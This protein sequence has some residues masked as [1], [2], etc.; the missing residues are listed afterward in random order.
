VERT[1]SDE[2]PP[3]EP[4]LDGLPEGVIAATLTGEILFWN[5]AAETIFGLPREA[6]VGRDLVETIIAAEDLEEVRGKLQGAIAAGEGTFECVGRRGDASRVHVDLSLKVS[7]GE[8][9]PSQVV[10]CI[11]DVTQPNIR[12]QAAELDLRFRGLLEAVPDAKVIVNQEGYIL[13]VNAQ[14]ERLFGYSRTELVGREVELL[15]PHRFRGKHPGHRMGYTADPRHRP[16]G[17]GMELFGL[18]KDGTEFPVEISL[19]SLKTDQGVLVFSAIRDITEQKRLKEELSRQYRSL[20][21]A[22]RLKSEFLANMSHELRTPLNAIIGFSELIHDAKVGPVTA[23][24]QEYLND[25]LNSSRH[26]LQLINDVLDLAK[27][28]AGKIEFRPAPLVLSQV[29]G[30]VRDILRTLAAQKRI[31][32]AV[33]IDPSVIGVVADPARLKQVLYNYLSNALKFS[34]DEGRVS[35]RVLA[36]GAREFRL[37]VEDVGIGIKAED[38]GRLFV[39]F[40]QLDASTAKKYAG[41]GLGLALTKRIVEAQQGRVGVESTPGKGSLFY[42]VLPRVS[43]EISEPAAV[44]PPRHEGGPHVLVIEDDPKDSDWLVRTLTDA[45]YTV[46]AARNGDEALRRSR[47]Q[48]FDAITL[49]LLLPDVSGRD[50]L[51]AIRDGLNHDTPVVIVSVVAER[52]IGTGFQV[53]DIFQKPVRSEELLASLERAA[54]LPDLSRPV[55]VVDDDASTLKLAETT[56]RQAGYWP[57]CCASATEALVAAAEEPPALVVLDLLMPEMDGFEFLRHFRSTGQGRRTPVIVWTV[58]DLTPGEREALRASARIV[59]AKGD[60]PGALVREL[61]S[62][63]S[64]SGRASLREAAHGR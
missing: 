30:E 6:A 1:T 17:A 23:E 55:L 29:I 59:V 5:R 31:E 9:L 4:S 16:M 61:E 44:T 57:V 7:S 56:L 35:V 58:K 50:L 43:G 60:G 48:V 21:E 2:S 24:Q 20:Q 51:K 52:G 36:E 33:D 12:R 32:I 22:N 53:H 46:E 15:V 62:H 47:E 39:E 10:L 40:Q 19:S 38:F 34:P 64:T 28:E 14:A 37:E 25:I 49:D 27:V 8:G 18:R 3:F 41:T 42:A 26:L 11:R 63:L 45:G 13:L 54:V